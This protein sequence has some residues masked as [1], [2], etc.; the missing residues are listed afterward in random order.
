MSTSAEAMA[1]AAI[2]PD[3]RM[4]ALTPILRLAA[5]L[6][7]F[8]AIQSATSL[9]SLAMLGRLGN[10]TLAGV[11]AGGAIY[12]V[13][14]ALLFGVDAAV[15]ATIA[16]RVGAGRGDLLGQ[17]LADALALA[18]PL[19]LALAALAWFA[20]PALVSAI[21]P[22]ARSAAIGATYLRAAAPSLFFLAVSI[23]IN[24]CWIGS[25]RPGRAL[26]V[27]AILAPI[28][29]GVTFALVFGAGPVASL[30][31]AGAGWA[32]SLA[33]L[34][35]VALQLAMA[36]RHV[37]IPG[38]GSKAPSMGGVR[39]IAA[40]GWPISLQQS[41]L[42]F[43][44]MIAFVIVARL[45]VAA[46]AATNV[47]VSLAIVPAQL[48]VGVGVAGG[49]LVGQSLGRN[50]PDGARRWGWRATGVGM[51]V[52]AP[53]ALIGLFATEPLL[54]LFLRDPATLAMALWPARLVALGLTADTV[55][56]VLCFTIRGA[57]ATRIGAA[58]P[59][60]AQW[61]AQLPLS[62]WLAVGLGFGLIGLTGVQA[63]VA[64]AEAGVTALFWAGSRWTFHRSLS[65]KV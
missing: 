46:V 49:I 60:A 22:E 28:Q 8:F 15:Q 13:V 9:A 41:L 12:G 53:F 36:T 24:S 38:F 59:F 4:A 58:I 34:I 57:G 33:A 64:I 35:G 14:L 32:S 26:L 18:A 6:T 16:R 37:A 47:L 51:A 2:A 52:T 40:I 27:T 25:G 63:G 20:A 23:P 56:R 5:P 7:A 50:D 31:A 39:A 10:S 19:G 29:I 44:M 62:W 11:G 42:Q 1:G 21:L 45:G 17:V 55:A 48:A 65:P 61:L 30:G 3:R 43:G 54:S